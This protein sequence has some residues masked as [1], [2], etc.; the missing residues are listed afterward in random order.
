M[1][2]LR[3]V[4]DGKCSPTSCLK[5]EIRSNCLLETWHL[6][7]SMGDSET[8]KYQFGEIGNTFCN[9]YTDNEELNR[10]GLIQ[11]RSN[12]RKVY[13]NP[14]GTFTILKILL[15]YFIFNQLQMVGN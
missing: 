5:N 2:M 10:R 9:V 12:L 7:I 3:S 4:I 1:N 8:E 11:N 15:Q 13:H 14:R 6:I